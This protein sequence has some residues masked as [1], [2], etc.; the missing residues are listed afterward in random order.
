MNDIIQSLPEEMQSTYYK[1]CLSDNLE[2]LSM[3]SVIL[4]DENREKI[5]DFLIETKYKS[6][7]VKYGLTPVNRIIAY[8]ASGTGKTFMT[9]CLAATFGYELLAIDIANALST[10]SAATALEDVFTLGNH[11]GHCIIF[12]DECDAI[13]RNRGNDKL[14]ED[15][16]VRRANNALFQQLDRMNTECVFVSATNLY[17]E[18]DPAFIRRFNL[19]MRFDIPPIDN[20]EEFINKFK[21][22]DFT[23]VEDMDKEIKN[24]LLY[25]AKSYTALSYYE[26][27]NWVQRAEKIAIINDSTEIKESDIYKFFMESMRVS[28]S[29]DKK[30]KLY[31]V[32]T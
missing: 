15:A 13:A 4:S 24:I 8:G 18:I 1:Y 16:N 29:K 28:V 12:L 7:F 2:G 20:L 21:H 5:D 6:K 3:D 26:I 22:P 11:I 23:I 17:K 25:H 31:L 14:Q 19:K 30:G 27:E 10:G 32:N 9:K